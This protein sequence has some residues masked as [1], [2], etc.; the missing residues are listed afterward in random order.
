MVEKKL[1]D[2]L[3]NLAAKTRSGE[4]QW[5]ETEKDDAFQVSFAKSS[6]VLAAKAID[7]RITVYNS[8]GKLIATA[9]DTDL[10]RVMSDASALMQETYT[11]ARHQALK[12]DSTLDN[13]L[14]EL[15]GDDRDLPF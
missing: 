3:R 9:T 14:D 6:I 7:F 4:V 15:K 2:I 8:N 11:L 10:A 12:V 1:A 13:T 5:E